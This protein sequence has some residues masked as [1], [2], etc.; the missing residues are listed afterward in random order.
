MAVSRFAEACL[1][2]RPTSAIAMPGPV[3]G[4]LLDPA[5]KKA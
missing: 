1:C 3:P 5:G 4:I 2:N